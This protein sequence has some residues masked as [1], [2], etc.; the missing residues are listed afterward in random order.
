MIVR[1]V[2]LERT[3]EESARMIVM[4]SLNYIGEMGFHR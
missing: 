1:G 4:R 2:G 3:I